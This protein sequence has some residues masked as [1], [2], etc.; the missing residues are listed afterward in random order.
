[1]VR[2]SCYRLSLLSSLEQKKGDELE[3][4]IALAVIVIGLLIRLW[5]SE[6]KWSKEEKNKF[7][8]L[9]PREWDYS[10]DDEDL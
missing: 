5:I 6:R 10:N 7:P 3:Y 8:E 9:E 1:M 4:F 2:L